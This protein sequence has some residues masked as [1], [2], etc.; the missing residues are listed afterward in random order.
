MA[1]NNV[2]ILLVAAIALVFLSPHCSAQNPG[3]NDAVA[4]LLNSQI[5]GGGRVQQN[6]DT[7]AAQI[8]D[9]RSTLGSLKASIENPKGDAGEQADNA[10]V[11]C[12]AVKE[13]LLALKT[14]TPGQLDNQAE[15]LGEA[16][17]NGIR[18]SKG[19]KLLAATAGD[20]G[21]D[22]TACPGEFSDEQYGRCINYFFTPECSTQSKGI[23][24]NLFGKDQTPTSKTLVDVRDV[25]LHI[26]KEVPECQ[27]LENNMMSVVQSETCRTGLEKLKPV[28]YAQ[29]VSNAIAKIEQQPSVSVV[30]ANKK[31]SEVAKAFTHLSNSL[32]TVEVGDMPSI[33]PPSPP[34]SSAMSSSIPIFIA[35]MFVGLGGIGAAMYFLRRE[36]LL[37]RL[38]HVAKATSAYAAMMAKTTEASRADMGSSTSDTLQKRG[39]P[40][41]KA[42]VTSSS[43]TSKKASLQDKLAMLREANAASRVESG[44]KSTGS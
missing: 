37:T 39:A 30:G 43:T 21:L 12:Q 13:A 2:Q 10:E 3:N 36:E 40:T 23:V 24:D 9:A 41:S 32:D 27:V 6:D 4:A 8:M 7:E 5:A 19:R 26:F 16:V 28:N 31:V 29:F 17:N 25:A 15:S 14:V 20:M 34:K 1:W 38:Q 33:P 22:N 18:L 35:F 42:V 44:K 11:I